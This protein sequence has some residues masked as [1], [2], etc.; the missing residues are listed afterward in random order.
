MQ[1][2]CWAEMDHDPAVPL[3][4]TPS[5]YAFPFPKPYD[6]QTDLMQTVFEAVERK[7]V[8]IVSLPV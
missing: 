6:I 1:L 4:D 5:Q 3:L 2:V 7:R 8:A